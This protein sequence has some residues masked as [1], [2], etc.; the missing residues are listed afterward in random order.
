MG[1]LPI[2]TLPPAKLLMS[3]VHTNLLNHDKTECHQ[4]EP[5]GYNP[6]NISVS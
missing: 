3:S 2:A 6:N 4:A 1:A 5:R